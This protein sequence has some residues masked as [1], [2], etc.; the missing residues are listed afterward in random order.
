MVKLSDQHAWLE[1]DS[2][3]DVQVGDWVALGMSH[4]CTIFEKWP[5]IPVVEADGAVTDYVRTFF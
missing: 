1:T 3:E 2:A 4:P 5:L